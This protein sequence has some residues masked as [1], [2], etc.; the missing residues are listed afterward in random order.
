VPS[1][2]PTL[3]ITHFAVAVLIG[4]LLN[5]NR[6]EWFVALTF[7]VLLDADHIFGAHRYIT[8]NGWAAVLRPTWD[9]GSGLPW[10]SLLHYPVGFFVV[11]PLSVGWN[12][13]LPLL[14]WGA[15]VGL[16]ELQGATLDHSAAIE[17]ALLVSACAG[18][19][20]VKYHRWTA[21]TPDG[22][23]SGYLSHIRARANA[24]LHFH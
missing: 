15:H 1:G 19:F 20:A 14:F 22:G 9:D 18:V 6:D 11:A 2:G 12:F 23:L 7:G 21:L 16:D 3:T 10:K 5:L 8:D 13:L 24:V 17:S 4:L